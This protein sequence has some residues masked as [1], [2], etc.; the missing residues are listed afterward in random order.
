ML[1]HF[2]P[3]NPSI[4]QLV[5]FGVGK[6][7]YL[8]FCEMR[9][10]DGVGYSTMGSNELYIL[11]DWLGSEININVFPY[12]NSRAASIAKHGLLLKPPDDFGEYL[13]CSGV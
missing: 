3:T 12:C 6:K 7:P 8:S 9:D 2:I 5:R 13:G 10:S 11:S 4:H 1:H